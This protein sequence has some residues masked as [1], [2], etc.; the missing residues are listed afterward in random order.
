MLCIGRCLCNAAPFFSDPLRSDLGFRGMHGTH[1]CLVMCI[2]RHDRYIRG[3]PI[4]YMGPKWGKQARQCA[5]DGRPKGAICSALIERL[6]CQWL[7]FPFTFRNQIPPHPPQKSPKKYVLKHTTKEIEE[8][9]KNKKR[10]VVRI[11]GR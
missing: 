10:Y 6:P 3:E 4:Y 5:I 9:I 7:S 1:A 2:H 8:K 11:F